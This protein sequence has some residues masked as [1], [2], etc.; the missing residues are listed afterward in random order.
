MHLDDTQTSLLDAVQALLDPDREAVTVVYPRNAAA[1]SK[2]PEGLMLS[3]A[4]LLSCDGCDQ[5]VPFQGCQVEG[6][7]TASGT[8][9]IESE[10]SRQHGCGTWAPPVVWVA[11]SFDGPLDPPVL[12]VLVERLRALVAEARA[13]RNKETRRRLCRE[14]A[15]FLA[16]PEDEREPTGSETG[17]GIYREDDRWVAWDYTCVRPADDTWDTI[18]VTEEDLAREDQP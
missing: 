18:D 16:L 8:L 12:P 11:A 13:D 10:R 6:Y 2:G 5:A 7:F 14:L 17:P 4:V 9:R 1:L 15:E 3:A